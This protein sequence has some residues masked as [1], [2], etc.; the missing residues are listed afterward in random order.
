MKNIFFKAT[1]ILL[2]LAFIFAG[3]AVSSLYTS[4]LDQLAM[5]I[6][7]PSSSMFE[8]PDWQRRLFFLVFKTRKVENIEYHFPYSC[9]TNDKLCFEFAD[10]LLKN[11]FLI[12][13]PHPQHG[14][15]PLQFSLFT[16]D[17]QYL[18]WALK[19]GAKP[20]LATATDSRF[21]IDYIQKS[22]C[23]EDFR[24]QARDLLLRYGT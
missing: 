23:S 13:T 12:D 11:G 3:F 18:E 19:N 4:R 14:Y 8:S 22:K 17:F 7:T 20:E 5:V 21:F 16:C 15:T 6:S 9:V 10:W 2:F 24:T 1:A